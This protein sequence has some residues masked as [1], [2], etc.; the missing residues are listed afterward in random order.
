V[1][2]FIPK[3]VPDAEWKQLY[4]NRAY[5]VRCREDDQI[6]FRLGS[7]KSFYLS[8]SSIKPQGWVIS[9]IQF[10]SGEGGLLHNLAEG[11]LLKLGRSPE[12]QVKIMH[13]II[14]RNHLEL[15]LRNSI[16]TV[17]D[18]GSVNGTYCYVGASFFDIEEYLEAQSNAKGDDL[19]SDEVHQVF[20]VGLDDFLK[21][22]REKK[23]KK[24]NEPDNNQPTEN[25]A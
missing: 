25:P 19:N 24:A 2:S 17:K 23:E 16:L 3:S 22:Y 14:S 13:A 21:N 8:I 6:Y 11:T 9:S 10:E 1:P 15:E 20:G 18:L 12:A 5:A 7:G 4:S